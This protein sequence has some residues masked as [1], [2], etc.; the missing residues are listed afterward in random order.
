VPYVRTV[1]T[2]S[3]ATAVQ[4]VY[5]YRRGS[6]DIEHIGSAHD[7]VE[8]ELLKAAARQRMAAG[9]GELDLGLQATEPAGRG[10]GGGP[11][12]I[13]STRMAHLLDAL[14]HAYRVLR[15]EQAAGG[16]EVFR[17]LVLARVIEPVSKL[18]SLRVL[19]EAGVA[20]ASYR[21]VAR[22]LRVYA[23]EAWRRVSVAVPVRAAGARR[24]SFPTRPR[25]AA[26][27][28]AGGTH[29]SSTL[30]AGRRR[31]KSGASAARTPRTSVRR[32]SKR[33]SFAI[34]PGV[35]QRTLPCA[36]IRAGRVG[37]ASRMTFL[38]LPKVAVP[39]PGARWKGDQERRATSRLR[40][41]SRSVVFSRS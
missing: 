33:A 8:L 27:R 30:A 38:F 16:D 37:S 17:Q 29:P 23:K 39:W 7:D 9:Q 1:K 20:A 13:T 36:L 19:E 31:S 25:P 18:D 22:R 3:G 34:S 12:P 26:G 4:I 11:L 15:L 2:E 24:R 41:M 35:H 10:R 28:R 6:R 5:S 32:I 21:T 40:A 14:E